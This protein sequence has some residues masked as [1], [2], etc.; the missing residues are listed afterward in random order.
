MTVHPAAMA[1]PTFRVIMANGKFQGVMEATTPIGWRITDS[2]L[3]AAE[4][5]IVSP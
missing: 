1:G 3:F 4:A 2:L 5:G